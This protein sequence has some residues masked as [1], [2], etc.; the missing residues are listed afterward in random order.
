M[1]G[2]N[3]AYAFDESRTGAVD[4]DEI[5]WLAEGIFPVEFMT[6]RRR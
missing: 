3:K 1:R 4:Y 5:L 2:R 6:P